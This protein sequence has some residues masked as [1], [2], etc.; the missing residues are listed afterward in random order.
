[1]PPELQS[2]REVAQDAKPALQRAIRCVT[3]NPSG[4]TDAPLAQGHDRQPKP[5]VVSEAP[6]R[7]LF[8]GNSQLMVCELPQMIEAMAESAPADLPRIKVGQFLAGGASLKTHWEAGAIASITGGKWDYVVIQEMFSAGR[9]DFEKY[10]ALFD[11]A[12]K[13]AGAKTVLFATASVTKHYS[14]AYGHPDSSKVLNDTQISLGK[15]MNIPIAAAGYAWM[16]YLGPN[17]SDE[18]VFDLYAEDKGHPGQK[19]SYIYACLLYAVIT[20]QNPAGLTSE[21]KSICG[22]ISIAREQAAK[23]QKAAWEQYLENCEE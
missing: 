7:V 17:P 11:E 10:A 8:I 5:I 20:R 13:K 12:I 6:I 4:A 16:R 21:F 23:M 9:H 1:M 3:P 22:G 19:G 15:R 2:K 14:T 18:E